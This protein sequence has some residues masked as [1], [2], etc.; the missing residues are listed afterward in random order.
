MDWQK[1]GRV[2]FRESQVAAIEFRY[3][4]LDAPEPDE[5]RLILNSGYAIELDEDETPAFMAWY[6]TWQ[7]TEWTKPDQP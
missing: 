6:R 7:V 4:S 5:V 1:I 2:T 3:S